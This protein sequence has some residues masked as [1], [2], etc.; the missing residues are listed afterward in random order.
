[1]TVV[2]APSYDKSETYERRSLILGQGT[3]ASPRDQPYQC[4]TPPLKSITPPSIPLGS[5]RTEISV[6]DYIDQSRRSQR[7]K[8]S[9]S[10]RERYNKADEIIAS[11]DP[12]VYDWNRGP[13]G[14]SFNTGK[15]LGLSPYQNRRHPDQDRYSQGIQDY[16]P[17]PRNLFPS[18]PYSD[19]QNAE[20]QEYTPPS[21]PQPTA[22]RNNDSYPSPTPSASKPKKTLFCEPCQSQ[23][24][25]GGPITLCSECRAKM[26]AMLHRYP[27]DRSGYESAVA[28]VSGLLGGAFIA[29]RVVA[30]MWQFPRL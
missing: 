24:E 10:N 6:P 2:A 19:S 28:F 9:Y 12:R 20:I 11:P 4:H 14:D 8:A 3:S 26:V 7:G 16:P 30:S 27:Q 13:N 17:K 21:I 1:M 23:A 18:S 5:D 25:A 22:P 29:A 15:E